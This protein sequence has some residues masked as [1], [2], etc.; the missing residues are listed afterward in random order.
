MRTPYL[1]GSTLLALTVS[2]VGC[3][4][5]PA[6]TTNR[7]PST[8]DG[9][10]PEGGECTSETE[11][12]CECP[13]GLPDGLRYCYEGSWGE[14]SCD[15][16]ETKPPVVM[17]G[18]CKPG[19]YEGEFW[20]YYFSSFTFGWAPIPVWAWNLSGAPGLA[21]TLNAV[22]EVVEPGAEFGGELEIS[23]GYVKG[24]ADG[25]FP[26][27]GKLTGKLDCS[28]KRF[29]ATLSGGYSILFDAVLNTADF[30]G[31]VLG[32]YDVPTKSFP[33]RIDGST[34]V[35]KCMDSP[36]L[37][38]TEVATKAAWGE[39]FPEPHFTSHWQLTEMTGLPQS[40]I[41]PHLEYG[42]KGYWSAQWVGEGMV[43]TGTGKPKP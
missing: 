9:D 34:A 36:E 14:C 38:A 22:G 35:P 30:E 2:L 27:E 3:A 23:D 28:T 33:C 42:G 37:R 32:N 25:L 12:A 7:L 39:K 21:F 5:D 43:D 1:L 4:D 8:G 26:F 16:G 11:E 10:E 19:R 15:D 18:A 40:P 24:T 31:P 13:D 29:E 20:G 41:F 17:A 6:T